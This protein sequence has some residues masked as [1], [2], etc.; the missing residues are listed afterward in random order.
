VSRGVH[1][2]DLPEPLHRRVLCQ[3]AGEP[4]RAMTWADVEALS[5]EILKR[6][7]PARELDRLLG[8]ADDEEV[9]R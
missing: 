5:A 4:V 6:P 7:D 1:I 9:A 8:L 3:L 2:D